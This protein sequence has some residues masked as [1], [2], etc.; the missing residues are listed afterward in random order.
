MRLHR[1]TSLIS[2]RKKTNLSTSSVH[3]GKNA[4]ILKGAD[5]NQAS[6]S[7]DRNKKSTHLSATYLVRVDLFQPSSLIDNIELGGKERVHEK[8][9]NEP[10]RAGCHF[11]WAQSQHSAV[12]LVQNN[13]ERISMFSS[14][15]AQLM[16]VVFQVLLFANLGR[17]SLQKSINHILELA[18]S[19][20]PQQRASPSTRSAHFKYPTTDLVT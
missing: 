6:K 17:F 10:V 9:G 19:N 16:L 3:N 8:K 20:K 12:F 7:S 14:F 4:A 1:G 2:A 13:H 18:I 5:R 11:S 15:Q